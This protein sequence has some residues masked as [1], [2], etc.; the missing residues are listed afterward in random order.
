MLR[1]PEEIAL[2]ASAREPGIRNPKR[3]EYGI[4]NI[5][6]DFMS[7]LDLNGHRVLELGPGHYGFC[8]AL[9][10]RGGK[11]EA[12]ELDPPVAELGRRRGF[13][14]HT[15]DLVRLPELGLAG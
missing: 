10:L 8:E 4:E 6:L 1:T 13:V 2:L 12:V 9:R 15:G 5:F 7:G 11:P 3:P 14:V